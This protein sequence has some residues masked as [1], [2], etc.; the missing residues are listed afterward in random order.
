M[1]VDHSDATPAEG[2]EGT[3]LAPVV[4]SEGRDA[5]MVVK[6]CVCFSRVEL[7]SAP[8]R[9]SVSSA[10]PRSAAGLFNMFRPHRSNFLNLVRISRNVQAG[11]VPIGA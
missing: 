11:A 2:D 7:P 9:S 4:A 1:S 6:W 8:A 3:S 10:R 5:K